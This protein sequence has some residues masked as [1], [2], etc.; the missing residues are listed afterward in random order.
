MSGPVDVDAFRTAVGRLASGV[1][2][3]TALV[4][5]AAHAMTASSVASVSLD[6]ALLLFCVH[7]DARFRDLLDDVDGWAVSVLADTQ[8]DVADWLASPGRPV[9]G[10][11]DR[12]P[13]RAAPV[14]GAPWV[15]GAAAWFD[16]R[17]VAVHEAGDHDVV[18][19]EVLAVV[20][21]EPALGGLVHLRGRVRGLR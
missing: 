13:H 21:G 2:V 19:G 20:Q 1:V 6:P 7:R 8:A 18:I 4:R 16:C 15:D 17:T 9:V 3:V 5:G 10:Q 12:V 11:L 14:S